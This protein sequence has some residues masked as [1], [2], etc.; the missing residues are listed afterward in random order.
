MYCVGKGM[1]F[2]VVHLSLSH[3]LS[4]P[5]ERLVKVLLDAGANIDAQS[6][7]GGTPL[8]RAIETSQKTIIKLL[9]ER[10]YVHTWTY[11]CTYIHVRRCTS[12]M[13]H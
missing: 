4:P 7:N 3:T 12:D 2:S 6:C 1:I 10:G 13:V 9:L 11:V 8:M 5:Q